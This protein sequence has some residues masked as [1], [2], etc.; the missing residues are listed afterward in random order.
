MQG[1]RKARYPAD[2]RRGGT[3]D[4]MHGVRGKASCKIN[5]ELK[6][7]K[8]EYEKLSKKYSLPKF[9]QLDEE[10]EIRAIELNKTGIL[11]KAV[12]RWIT[13]KLNLFMSYLE[14][15]ISVPPQNIHSLIEMRNLSEQERNKMFE[16]YKELSALLHENLT[17]ELKS[18]KEIAQQ[19]KKIW[20]S[21][22]EIKGKEIIF[23]ENMTQA[24]RKKE[25]SPITKAEYS[26]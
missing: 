20:K 18:E 5:M 15:V 6:E 22:P 26:G 14:P 4:K 2:K 8:D 11:I 10:F 3:D 24:W 16:F 1:M 23:L 13:N 19:I 25:E 7:L 21:W 9:E 12:L 17:I